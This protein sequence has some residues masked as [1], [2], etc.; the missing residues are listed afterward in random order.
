MA[1]KKG[2]L[3]IEREGLIYD[4][5]EKFFDFGDEMGTGKMSVVRTAKCKVS[6]KDYAAKM[7]YFDD[8]SL[9]FAIREYDLMV[10]GTMGHKGLV[11]L[12]QAYMVRKY[13]VLIMELADGKTLLDQF[14]HRHSLT[15]DDVAV[16]IQQLCEV[17]DFMH[18][19]TLSILIY[20]PQISVLLAE[21]LNFSIT[22]VLVTWQ[23]KKLVQSST[24]LVILNF[25]HLKC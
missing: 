3:P 17:L 24:S 22:T 15:E 4:N 7:I 5:P 1:T 23:T 9:K 18:H 21:I 12:H 10:S 16:V 6:G 25:V 11:Q 14:C 20:V 19:K 2:K 13:L 8:D